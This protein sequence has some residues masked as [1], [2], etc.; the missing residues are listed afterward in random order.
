MKDDSDKTRMQF[1]KVSTGSVFDE[2]DYPLVADQIAV[3]K[4]LINQQIPWI[5]SWDDAAFSWLENVFY[6]IMQVADLWEVRSAF[7][8]TSRAQRYF[9]ISNHWYYLLEKDPHIS[10]EYAAVEY[11]AKYGKGLGRFLSR[12]MLPRNAA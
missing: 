5:I 3:H 6:P 9:A 8:H 11:A 12:L 4:Y 7:P 2:A 1:L 10:A